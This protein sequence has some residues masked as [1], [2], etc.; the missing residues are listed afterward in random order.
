MVSTP[1]IADIG[2][3]APGAIIDDITSFFAHSFLPI[4]HGA[5]C[6]FYKAEPA[7][8]LPIIHIFGS[9]E[10]HSYKLMPINARAS[11]TL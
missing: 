2:N 10:G 4:R 11:S 8:A 7:M 9:W 6:T 5:I 3:L 1:V